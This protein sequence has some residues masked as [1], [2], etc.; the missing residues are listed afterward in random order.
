MNNPKTNQDWSLRAK[1]IHKPNHNLVF[2]R[3]LRS[4]MKANSLTI[5]S[6]PFFPFREKG[7]YHIFAIWKML[8]LPRTRNSIHVVFFIILPYKKLL[9]F[10]R[11]HIPSGRLRGK[12][13]DTKIWGHWAD[14]LRQ[15]N[16]NP[17]KTCQWV[18]K[19]HYNT[20]FGLWRDNHSCVH[21]YG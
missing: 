14:R 16:K 2:S 6:N 8:R 3:S 18:D 15:Y 21:T 4:D 17:S 5:A 13:N 10:N 19:T 11:S 9:F 12:Q 1:L 20:Y 7:T